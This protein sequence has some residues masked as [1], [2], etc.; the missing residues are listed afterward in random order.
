ML[1]PRAPVRR[2]SHAGTK[3]LLRLQWCSRERK[4]GMKA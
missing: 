4:T 1:A 2:G 3:Y